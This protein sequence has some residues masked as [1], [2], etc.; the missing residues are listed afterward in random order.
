[1]ASDIRIL[2]HGNP[3]VTPPITTGHEA[4]GVIVK[5]GA[6]ITHLQVGDRISIGADVP[7]GECD[8]CRNGLGNNCEVNYAVGYQIPGAFAEYMKLPG[9]MC[10][11]GPITK[12]NRCT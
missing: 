7:C 1:M 11:E 10:K 12:T 8:W 4:S 9:L 2:H 6:N 3:R 5:V